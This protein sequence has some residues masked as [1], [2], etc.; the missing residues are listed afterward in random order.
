MSAERRPEV[1]AE[2]VGDGQGQRPGPLGE[3]DL[4]RAT[5]R[6]VAHDAAGDPRGQVDGV[7]T[8]RSPNSARS[9]WWTR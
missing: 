2:G 1:L 8:V 7:G 3:T 5:H 6:E 9:R 4:S